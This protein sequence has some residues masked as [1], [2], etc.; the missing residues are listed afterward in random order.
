VPSSGKDRGCFISFTSDFQDM[1]T[2]GD[3]RDERVLPER[4]K[5]TGDT[6]K[7]VIVKILVRKDK[8]QV[9]QPVAAQGA[10][11]SARHGFRKVKP[12]DDG[13]EGCVFRICDNAHIGIV[14]GR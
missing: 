7:S 14:P 8:H 1:L 4:S 5:N 10:R 6:F 2:P 9:I 11:V 3:R 12:G 13:P